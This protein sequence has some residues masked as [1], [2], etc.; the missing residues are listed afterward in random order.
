LGAGSLKKTSV[1]LKALANVRNSSQ[2]DE[3][4]K[5]GVTSG[6]I[7]YYALD[8]EYRQLEETL[9]KLEQGSNDTVTLDGKKEGASD[10][11]VAKGICA[12]YEEAFPHLR[13]GSYDSNNTG[14]SEDDEKKCIMFLGSSIG[15]YSRTEAIEFL[16][17]IADEGM[18]AG[19]T[20]LIGI[21]STDDK[22]MI[23]KAYNDSDNVTRSFILNGIDHVNQILGDVGLKQ[24]DFEYK[25]RY[26]KE[27]GRHEVHQYTQLLSPETTKADLKT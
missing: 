23:E 20:L 5:E 1:L 25:N 12:S 27:K 13:D 24:D 4:G 2:N 8:L 16:R 17:Q 18:K 7:K 15:N 21:D 14:K 19:D 11:I 26:N 22:P 3:Q 6:K 10:K 9:A